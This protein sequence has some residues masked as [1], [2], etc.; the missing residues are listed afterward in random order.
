MFSKLITL[1]QGKL[2]FEQNLQIGLDGTWRSWPTMR[3]YLVCKTDDKEFKKYDI[4]LLFWVLIILRY[5][6]DRITS[7]FL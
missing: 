1:F 3:K 7:K 2:F 4:F 5:K 6:F